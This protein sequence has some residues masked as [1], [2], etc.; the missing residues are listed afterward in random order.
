[1]AYP[2]KWLT[3]K[4][5][6]LYCIPGKFFIDPTYPVQHAIITHGHADH[7]R[8]G[9]QHV[10]AHHHTVSIMKVR[11]GETCAE[12]FTAL[13]Y[14]QKIVLGDVEIYLLPAGHILGSSQ[15]VMSYQNSRVII[16]GDFKRS[17][18]PTCPPFRVEPCEIFIT[19]ATFSLPVFTHP[20]IADEINK[21]RQSIELH[22]DRGHLVGVYA[23]GKCQ[24]L[25]T[26]LRASGYHQ[27]IYLHGALKKLC[28]LYQDAGI[29]LGMVLPATELDSTNSMGKL[30][31]CPP[32]ALHDKWSRR[33]G[34]LICGLA[35][36]W[37]Q[38]R[39]RAKQKGIDLP[40]IISDHADWPELTR[41]IH[42]V[43]PKE[44]WVTH[45]REDA[46][47]YYAEKNGYKAQALRL[48]GYEEAED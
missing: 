38:I 41:T 37:M 40:L 32:S 30:V 4:K 13:A 7:A 43:N 24:R 26:E 12:C 33:F 22:S 39:A 5:Q 11:Y 36:G 9:H 14:Q 2:K 20:P 47:V 29:D 31:L 10:V 6:G 45:G 21:L 15:V 16:S 46:L 28:D 34:A 3:I 1:M 23:L 35:S 27:P 48:L 17:A 44:V 18:D 42:E 19:E 25:I 8:S